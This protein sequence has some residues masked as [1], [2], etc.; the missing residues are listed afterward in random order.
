MVELHSVVVLLNLK[1]PTGERKGDRARCDHSI[2]YRTVRCIEMTENDLASQR[3]ICGDNVKFD[4][5][6]SMKLKKADFGIGCSSSPPLYLFSE[7]V[8]KPGTETV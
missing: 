2:R 8:V 7:D 6:A 1:Q 5:R 3:Q 4:T